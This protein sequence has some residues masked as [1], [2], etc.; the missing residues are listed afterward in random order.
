MITHNQDLCI[1]SSKKLTVPF[2]LSYSF[3]YGR[4]ENPDL[5]N[6]AKSTLV[7]FFGFIRASFD[8]LLENGRILQELYSDCIASCS[9]GKKV[10]E[11]WL[12][13]KDFGASRYLAKSAME[14]YQWF[15]SL[16]PKIQRLIRS[17]VQSWSVSALRQLRKVSTDLLEEVISGRKKTAAQIKLAVK[18]SS[19]SSTKTTVNNSSQSPAPSTPKANDIK[20][21]PG[22]RI[23]VT[24]DDS[25]WNGQSGIIMSAHEG[26]FWV[27][28]DHTVA[29]GMEIKHLF[30]PQQLQLELKTGAA[31]VTSTQLFTAAQ[32]EEQIAEALAVY[33]KEKA[34]EELGR[35]V[36]I[37]DAALKAAGAEIQSYAQHARSLEQAKQ[38]LLKQLEIK[39]QELQQVRSLQAR[40]KQLEQRVAELEKAL[41]A[42]NLNSWGNTFSNQAAK[43]IN[44]QVEKTVAPLMSEVERLKALVCKQDEELALQQQEIIKWR[45]FSESNTGVQEII[46][47]FSEIAETLGWKGWNRHGYHTVDG[48]LHRDINAI[49]SFIADLKQDYC[50]APELVFQN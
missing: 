11:T 30:K 47:Q 12:N 43:V 48:T 34:E 33:K 25:G 35:F 46:K 41:E 37:Q 15:Q 36:E 6:R 4:F 18:G 28:M 9:S 21:P 32:V 22:I 50:E 31:K 38:E 29:Q 17:K 2:L 49:A 10:F 8:G 39:E 3:N 26:K 44:S 24:G 27:L 40:N 1:T 5:E 45:Q 42:S 19:V 14:I 13:S 20:L 16:N 7:S 23:V